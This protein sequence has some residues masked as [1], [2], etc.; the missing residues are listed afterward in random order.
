ML[1]MTIAQLFFNIAVHSGFPINFEETLESLYSI[2]FEE[3]GLAIRDILNRRYPDGI[4][5]LENVSVQGSKITGLFSDQ[6]FSTLVK[7]FNFS[8][9]GETGEVIYGQIDTG[10][11]DYT[12]LEFAAKKSQ[13]CTKGKSFGCTRADGT[14]Y[15]LP[16]GR[17]C[18]SA[19]L[20]QEEIE[21]VKNIIDKAPKASKTKTLEV[22]KVNPMKSKAAKKDDNQKQAIS[23]STLDDPKDVEKA[24]TAMT[25]S[26]GW[27]VASLLEQK[28]KALSRNPDDRFAKEMYALQSKGLGVEFTASDAQI[29]SA[30]SLLDNMLGD[31]FDPDQPEKK[32]SVILN[33]KG[34]VAAAIR[35][36]E[37]KD[38]IYVDFLASS[39]SN[40]VKGDEV[41]G[42]GIEA[43]ATLVEKSIKAG[44]SGKLEL[45]SLPDAAEFYKKIGFIG[46]DNGGSMVLPPEAAKKFYKDLK[47]SVPT[48]KTRIKPKET[49]KT[50]ITA[51]EKE[52]FRKAITQREVDSAQQKIIERGIQDSFSVEEIAAVRMYTTSDFGDT[53]KFLRGTTTEDNKERQEYIQSLVKLTNSVLNKSPKY[54]GEVYRGAYLDSRLAKSYQVGQIVEEKSFTSSTTDKSIAETFAV[55]DFSATNDDDDSKPSVPKT[56][57]IYSIKSKSGV[58][59]RDIS[60]TPKEEEVLFKTNTKF[61]V[62][63]IEKKDGITHIRMEE[64]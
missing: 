27:L 13:T 61:R 14:V 40:F 50:K 58:N 29:L 52:K 47:G 26:K 34:D 2:D 24:M 56:S 32:T 62:S 59:I 17:K 63:A 54:T 30:K 38:S 48:T 64:L 4:S 57:I 41:K 39:P 60:K 9:D 46:D 20:S 43:L 3:S 35:Y 15:C 49:N 23:F 8:I 31:P 6:I 37:T 42:A 18:A 33:K 7:K 55:T 1:N 25:K 22:P 5:G 45:Y 51:R 36:S 12:E 21:V 16:L 11:L 44:F 53:N 28:E 19:K 10:N